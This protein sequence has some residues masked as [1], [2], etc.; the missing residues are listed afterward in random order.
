MKNT[1]KLFILGLAFAP[2]VYAGCAQT[3][4]IPNVDGVCEAKKLVQCNDIAIPS[5]CPPLYMCVTMDDGVANCQLHGWEPGELNLES[6]AGHDSV[7]IAPRIYP[8]EMS[9]ASTRD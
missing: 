4:R 7:V 3:P 2:F 6:T 5:C 1:I 8:N 9:D